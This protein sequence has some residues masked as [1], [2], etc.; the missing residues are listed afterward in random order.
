MGGLYIDEISFVQL[1]GLCS[2]VIGVCIDFN[3]LG[4]GVVST[5]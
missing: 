5:D 2:R 4:C 1:I 3:S